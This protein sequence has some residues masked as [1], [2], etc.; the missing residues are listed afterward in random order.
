MKER[1]T[2]FISPRTMS[3]T[4]E[5]PINE[6]D[7][8]GESV[9]SSLTVSIDHSDDNPKTWRLDDVQCSPDFAN[10][11]TIRGMDPHK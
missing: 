1:D 10:V 9:S 6:T 2:P 7:P 3:P 5:P 8:R 4:E 11:L